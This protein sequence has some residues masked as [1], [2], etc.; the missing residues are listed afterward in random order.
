LVTSVLKSTRF[1]NDGHSLIIRNYN[2]HGF[3]DLELTDTALDFIRTDFERLRESGMKAIVRFRYTT[4]I[5]DPDA[6]LEIVLRH[7]EQLKPLFQEYY[8]V[9]AVLNAG[10]IGAWGEW[11]ASTHNLTDVENQRAILFA[12]L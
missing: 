11:H 1:F 9:I 10:F 7:I 4:A 6:P 8:D 12:L 5:G 2:L 3:R